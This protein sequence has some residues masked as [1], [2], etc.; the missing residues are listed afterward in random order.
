MTDL[1]TDFDMD[2]LSSGMFDR[3]SSV[4]A[5]MFGFDPD[6]QHGGELTVDSRRG[7]FTEFVVT[8]PRT[9]ATNDGVRT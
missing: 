1:P 9:L 2:A 3:A 6:T 8:L 7:A 4:L 5:D